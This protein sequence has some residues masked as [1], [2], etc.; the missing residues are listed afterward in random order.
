MA[1]LDVCQENRREPECGLPGLATRLCYQWRQRCSREFQLHQVTPPG[2][3]RTGPTPF[4]GTP[5][6]LAG[7]LQFENF[8]DGGSGIAYADT[9]TGNAG[10]KYRAT[11]V[12]IETTSDTGGGYDVGWVFAGEWLKYTVNVTTA[13]V[14]DLDFRVASGGTGGTFHI[15]VNGANVTGPISVPTTNGWQ[16]WQTIR[17]PAGVTLA[18]GTQVWRVVMDTNGP[19]TAVGN[20]NWLKATLR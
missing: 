19:S 2:G 14:Y 6:A 8:D 20:F 5:T 3:R 10:G 18:A 9:S 12:D 17:V 15:E 7:T 13:G 16:T 11:D 4:G 1:E